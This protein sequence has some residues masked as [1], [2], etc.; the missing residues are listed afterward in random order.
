VTTA[1]VNLRTAKIQLLMFLND[2]MPVEQFDVNGPFDFVD[3]L[4]PLSEFRKIALDTRP[5]LKAAVQWID[6]ARTDHQLAIANGSTDPTFG[7][8][9]GRNPPL[10]HYL[11]VSVT[12]SAATAVGER[13][14]HVRVSKRWGITP[15][16]S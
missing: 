4:S 6:K 5:D 9:A 15:R 2:R 7:V 13:H 14:R 11:G 12:I 8:D 1:Q 16:F 3:Q 10:D